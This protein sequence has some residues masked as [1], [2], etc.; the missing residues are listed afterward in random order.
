MNVDNSISG[1]Y[2][3]QVAIVRCL[4]K[5]QGSQELATFVDVLF[6]ELL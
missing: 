3:Y 6:D 4:V 5:V 2:K 1:I